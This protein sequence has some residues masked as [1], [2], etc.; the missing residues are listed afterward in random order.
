[1]WWDGSL[2]PGIAERYSVHL[3]CTVPLP[4]PAMDFPITDLMDEDACYARLVE[5]LHPGGFVCPRCHQGDR[6]AIHRRRRPPVL[7]FR[8]GHCGRVFNAFTGTALH[9]IKRGPVELVLIIRDRK[10]TRLNSSH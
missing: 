9:G 2:W 1:M 7:D 3:S 5:W 6:M 8:C 4:E 10:S